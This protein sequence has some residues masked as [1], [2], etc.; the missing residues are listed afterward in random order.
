MQCFTYFLSIV[1][2]LPFIHVPSL[3]KL[4]KSMVSTFLQSLCCETAYHLLLN[5][6]YLNSKYHCC[7]EKNKRVQNDICKLITV[8]VSSYFD[9]AYFQIPTTICTLSC[10]ESPVLTVH[11]NARFSKAY[12]KILNSLNG[13]KILGQFFDIEK[14]NSINNESTLYPIRSDCMKLK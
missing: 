2:Y 10:H 1:L 6:R 12:V 9:F 3:F 4:Y 8:D 13:C 14:F 7:S 5:R 11:T